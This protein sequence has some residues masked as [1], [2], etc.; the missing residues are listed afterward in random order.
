MLYPDDREKLIEFAK[1][2]FDI[3]D[4]SSFLWCQCDEDDDDGEYIPCDTNY[5]LY[6]LKKLVGASSVNHGKTK[7]VFSF[8]EIPEYVFKLPIAGYEYYAYLED[9][10]NYCFRYQEEYYGGDD[11]DAIELSLERATNEDLVLYSRILHP[12]DYCSIESIIYDQACKQNVQKAFAGTWFL[13]EINGINIYVSEKCDIGCNL[14][15]GVNYKVA[16]SKA[17]TP[18]FDGYERYSLTCV[19]IYKMIVA[20]GY[21]FAIKLYRFIEEYNITDLHS[22][23]LG[24]NDRGELCIL[25]YSGFRE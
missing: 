20:F 23:N 25:D 8:N 12:G 4:L 19:D 7:V 11:C 9:N 10:D 21:S 18:D 15:E 5:S 2:R 14:Y 17:C 3:G 22:G 6:T 16:K 1:Q 13:C 24:L